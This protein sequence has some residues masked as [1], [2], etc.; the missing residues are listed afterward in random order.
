[1]KSRGLLLNL[2][3]IRVSASVQNSLGL[4]TRYCNSITASRDFLG[5]SRMFFEFQMERPPVALI[6]IIRTPRIGARL[7]A[8]SQEQ[9]WLTGWAMNNHNNND[10]KERLHISVKE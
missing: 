4:W 6:C 5:L 9:F 10:Y 3:L 8:T 7:Q 1:M 2:A